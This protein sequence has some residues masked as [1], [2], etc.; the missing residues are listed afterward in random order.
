VAGKR[1]D[2]AEFVGK[3][4]AA[5]D[6]DVLREGVRVL[7]QALMGAEVS[8]QIGA[9]PH[10]RSPERTAHRNGYRERACNTRVGTVEL[11]I[12]KV[13]PGTYFPSL[14]E[15]R[16][17]AER[18]LLAVVQEAFV[19][20]VSTRK[21]DDLVRALGLE[22]IP[23]SKVSRI[24]AA[25]DS[26]VQ[27]FLQRPLEGEYRTCGSTPPTTRCDGPAAWCRWRPSWR[28]ASPRRVS[29]T[30]WASR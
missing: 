24:C 23:K 15:P 11:R 14:L 21:V 17:R 12:P 7:A 6:V 4:V 26:E 28:S 29:A 1:I 22:G 2:L 5:D 25:L 18:A 20:G 30:S 3:L 8:S 9:Q 27:A 19:H 13:V 10:A 16:R